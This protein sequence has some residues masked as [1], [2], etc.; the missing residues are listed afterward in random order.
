MTAPAVAT[1]APIVVKRDTQTNTTTLART[2]YTSI[3]KKAN[4]NYRKLLTAN[5][6]MRKN[7]HDILLINNNLFIDIIS[8]LKQYKAMELSYS[9]KAK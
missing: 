2:V 7:E 4:N 9:N 3:P 1:A 6:R 5:N 8:E